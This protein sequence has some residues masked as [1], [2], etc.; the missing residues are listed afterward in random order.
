MASFTGGPQ[1]PSQKPG[2]GG[3]PNDNASRSRNQNVGAVNE[4]D[5]KQKLKDQLASMETAVSKVAKSGHN[6]D[7]M[8]SASAASAHQEP[9]P[10]DNPEWNPAIEYPKP[11]EKLTEAQ[12]G[13]RKRVAALNNPRYNSSA[14][15][16]SK[17]PEATGGAAAKK[18]QRMRKKRSFFEKGF[19]KLRRAS[20]KIRT[21]DAKTPQERLD[22]I[23]RWIQQCN[24]PELLNEVGIFR[25]PSENLT[26]KKGSAL[27]DHD[28]LKAR[29]KKLGE[30]IDSGTINPK[31]AADVIKGRFKHKGNPI[32]AKIVQGIKAG[33]PWHV[34]FG[35]RACE[36]I[37]DDSFRACQKEFGHAFREQ[38]TYFNNVLK[39]QS[40]LQNGLNSKTLATCI[41]PEAITDAILDK[42][43]LP[44]LDKMK[45]EEMASQITTFTKATK[46]TE[47]IMRNFFEL[48]LKN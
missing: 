6:D 14:G 10:A 34:K 42:K 47:E 12:E 3:A 31:L 19:K 37:V 32:I 45:P 4:D 29:E 41:Q 13:E 1:G 25:I 48:C 15:G 28:L 39:Q 44:S 11:G 18:P 46:L 23:N 40:T 27:E 22:D 20:S 2:K 36:L 35:S 16:E 5:L 21:R 24:K 26:D 33:D 30:E 7:E 38:T 8:S 43:G 17:A 9:W